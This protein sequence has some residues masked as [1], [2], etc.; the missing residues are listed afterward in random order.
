MENDKQ[1][2]AEKIAEAQ[3][4]YIRTR[5]ESVVSN[6]FIFSLEV[7]IGYKTVVFFS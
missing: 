4:F 2:G 5:S 1:S 7:I 3:T 6:M